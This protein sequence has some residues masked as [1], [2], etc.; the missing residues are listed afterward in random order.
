VQRGTNDAFRDAVRALLSTAILAALLP[1]VARGE[2][3]STSTMAPPG[4]EITIDPTAD[5]AIL[6]ASAAFGLLL[7]LLVRTG[8]LRPQ[9]PVD[10]QQ[11]LPIDRPR[12]L[13]DDYQDNGLSDI[14]LGLMGVYALTDVVLA[15]VLDRDEWYDY[16]MMY[17]QGAAITLALT[18]LAKLA[19]RRP[20]PIAYRQVREGIHPSETNTA[21]SFFSGHASLAGCL[22]ATS[23][24]LVWL[25]DDSTLLEKILVTSVGALL[26]VGVGAFRVLE[27]DHFPTD[28]I[29]GALVGLGVGVLVPQIH[30]ISKSATLDTSI[31]HEA[32]TIGVRVD[33]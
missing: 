22:A 9:E 20:R 32:V 13:S 33:L 4:R 27:G 11:L 23:A 28:V 21:L 19:V 12:A 10:P 5:G 2:S 6:G 18:N 29:A 26:V 30:V 15:G 24:H 16:L 1:A 31:S 25:R 7:E 8:E 14:T 17:G 3:T